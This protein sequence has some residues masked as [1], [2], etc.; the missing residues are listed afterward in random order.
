MCLTTCHI[1]ITK[2]N[3]YRL[4]SNEATYFIIITV[5]I[6]VLVI[7]PSAMAITTH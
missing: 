2:S 1:I 3:N 5:A 7:L 6:P 4:N